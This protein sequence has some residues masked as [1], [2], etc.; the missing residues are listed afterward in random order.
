MKQLIQNFKTGEL[1]LEEL[2]APGLAGS[3]VRVANAFSLISAGTERGT[4]Q[5]AQASLLGKARL[6]PDLVKQVL[7]N[8]RREG[9]GATVDKVRNKLESMKALGYS[10]AGVVLESSCAA[11]RPGDRVA[12]AGGGYA[13]HAD[14]V[15]IPR[16]LCVAVPEGVPLDQAAFTT[17]GAIALQGVRQ[18]QVQLGETVVVI[19]MGLLGLL[20]GAILRANGCRVIGADVSTANFAAARALGLGDCCPMGELATTVERISRGRGADAVI[21]CASTRSN[22]PVEL[23]GRISRKKGRIV[24]VG[25]VGMDLPREPDFYQKELELKLSCSYGPGRYDPS[26]EEGGQDYPAAYVRWTEGR[27]MEAFLDLLAAGLD[28]GPLISHRFT[29]DRA[30]A[31]YDIVLGKTPEAHI[32]ILLEYPESAR[33]SG[34]GLRPLRGAAPAVSQ[35]RPGIAFLGAGSFAQ[36]YLLPNVVKHGSRPLKAVVTATGISARTV[37]GKF[38]FERFGTD[39]AEAL[40]DPGVD[41]VF[42][43]TRHDLHAPLVLQ[44]LEAGKH[45]FVEKPLC[46]TAGELAAIS[47]RIGLGGAPRLLVGFNRRFAPLLGRLQAFLPQ[48]EPRVIHYRVNAGMIPA[49]SWIQDPAIGGGRIMGELC[50]FIDTCGALAGSPLHSLNAVALP[51]GGRWHDDNLCVT[52]VYGNGSLATIHY[53][54]NGSS[55]MAKERIEVFSGGRSA[56]LDDFSRLDLYS[57]RPE[58]HKAAQDKGHAA[59]VAAFLDSLGGGPAPIPFDSLRETTAATLLVKRALAVGGE[60]VLAPFLDELDRGGA[61]DH[62]RA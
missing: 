55:R 61:L 12:C 10:S 24:V 26:Y 23:A 37:A 58:S 11:F 22:G 18:A 33:A 25:A 57:S 4:V 39:A 35:G 34:S 60:Q 36:G 1:L 21:L 62:T 19:G 54:A 28:L 29:I 8:V 16:N 30:L 32:G 46:L 27:N 17:L 49:T 50:H 41:T 44:A 47:A 2:P 59:E 43:A 48:G 9:L 42:I 31:A 20:A 40:A 56:V 53:L 51:N 38:G 52:L 13:V 5:T 6:R 3:G 15:Y 7:D 14:Q 45:V